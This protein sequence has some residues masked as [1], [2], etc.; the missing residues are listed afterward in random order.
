MR[1]CTAAT[2]LADDLAWIPPVARKACDRILDPPIEEAKSFVDPSASAR[3]RRWLQEQGGH[4]SFNPGDVGIQ[5]C[6]TMRT[7]LAAAPFT[8]RCDAN[9]LK[10]NVCCLK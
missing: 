4:V 10:P 3:R 6:V 5:P 9:L 7:R 1:C 8:K 2:R